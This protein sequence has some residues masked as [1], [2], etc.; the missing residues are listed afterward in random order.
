[1]R[2]RKD[3]WVAL[4]ARER[5]GLLDR[6]IADTVA[7]ARLLVEAA[8]AA[9]GMPGDELATAEEWIGSPFLT[10][11][12]LRRLRVALADI[13]AGRPPT[14]PGGLRTLPNGQAAARVFPQLRLDRVAFIERSALIE[15][16]V[17]LA[18]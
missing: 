18:G 1:M 9:K 11:D 15:L 4:A 8:V 17:A 3:A 2:A 7:I 6:M 16:G 13:A 14:I 5:L 12:N 10:L